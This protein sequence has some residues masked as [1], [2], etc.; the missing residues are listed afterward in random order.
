MAK[1]L[2]DLVQEIKARKRQ[3]QE[4]TETVW[5]VTQEATG[6]QA[7]NTASEDQVRDLQSQIATLVDGN[8]RLMADIE[9]IET[10]TQ[11][12]VSES[13]DEIARVNADC[14]VSSN[15]ALDA[16]THSCGARPTLTFDGIVFDLTDLRRALAAQNPVPTVATLEVTGQSPKQTVNLLDPALPPATTKPSTD[17]AVLRLEAAGVQWDVTPYL[18]FAALWNR[19]VTLTLT[20]QDQT[21]TVRLD[22][23]TALTL[24][25]LANACRT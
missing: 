14:A 7:K 20:I 13:K 6:L 18:A 10:N 23:P 4:A 2:E 17:R 9:E 22:R 24:P 19:S 5:K 21:G 16:Y 8:T 11:R 12:Q 1:T 3:Y 15:A 25:S